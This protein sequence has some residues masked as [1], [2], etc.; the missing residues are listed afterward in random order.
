MFA[1]EEGDFTA[2]VSSLNRS[3]IVKRHSV[4]HKFKK[5]FGQKLAI[6]LESREEIPNTA[7][8]LP[9]KLRHKPTRHVHAAAAMQI[10]DPSTPRT[11]S[12]ALGAF[13]AELPPSIGTPHFR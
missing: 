1:S 13:V 8:Q 6:Y 5:C 11:I 9:V 10:S 2:A 7:N 12:T 3:L 4:L